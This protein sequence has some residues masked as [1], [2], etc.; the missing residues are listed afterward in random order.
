MIN[1][2][3]LSTRGVTLVVLDEADAMLQGNAGHRIFRAVPKTAQIALFSATWPADKLAIA[4]KV[5]RSPVRIGLGE[6]PRI[7]E[8]VTH[9]RVEVGREEWKF[10]TLCDLYETLSLTQCIVFV[11]SN[12]KA[13]WLVDKLQ[14]CDFTCSAIHN[15]ME[16]KERDIIMREFRCDGGPR[17]II[18]AGILERGIDVRQV[19]GSI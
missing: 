9:Y 16:Q 4:A 10:D 19:G 11:D 3:A 15:E 5:C 12:R 7:P 6:R 8:S 14:Q 17:V 1:C 18:S 13:D 2:R